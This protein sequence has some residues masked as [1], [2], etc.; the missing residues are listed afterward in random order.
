MKNSENAE[1]EFFFIMRARAAAAANDAHKQMAVYESAKGSRIIIL[2]KLL[3]SLSSLP[4]D[5][6]DYFVEAAKCLEND[7]LR[8]AI[9][10]SWS[11]FFYTAS[12]NLFSKHEQEIR[13]VRPKWSFTNFDEFRENNT[14]SSIIDLMKELKV[15]NKPTWRVYQGQLSHRNQCAHPTLY[16]PSFN[17]CLGFVDDMLRQTLLYL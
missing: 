11:G 7:L 8:A 10:L 1:E 14:E 16:K 5:V 9:V 4:Y 15:V 17:S 12:S 13:T 3:E 6:Q 2:D